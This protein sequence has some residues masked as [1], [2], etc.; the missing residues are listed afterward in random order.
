[1]DSLGWV[2]VFYVVAGFLGLFFALAGM[3]V[4]L[5]IAAVYYSRNVSQRQSPS[6]IH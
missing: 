2:L 3:A 4:L 6:R 1:M 5:C